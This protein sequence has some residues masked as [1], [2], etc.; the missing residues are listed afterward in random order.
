M[1]MPALPRPVRVGLIALVTLGLFGLGA[2]W[3][4]PD[5]P[6]RAAALPPPV[7][8]LDVAA[9]DAPTNG[10]LASFTALIPESF[11]VDLPMLAR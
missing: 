2:L 10:V 5:E 9:A 8:R 11:L 4:T 1:S 7:V 3:P 6:V